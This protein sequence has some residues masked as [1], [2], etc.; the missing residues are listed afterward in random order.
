MFFVTGPRFPCPKV[1]AWHS[2]TGMTQYVKEH[3]FAG[4][5]LR[6]LEEGECQA[7]DTFE[8]LAR[9]HPSY[10]VQRVSEGLWGGKE[11]EDNSEEF[12]QALVAMD[13]LID[14]GYRETARNRLAR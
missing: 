10:T 4:Y 13:E 12:L 1:D 8:L 7:G 9:P 11:L 3:G 2:A 6:V 5:F 14:R